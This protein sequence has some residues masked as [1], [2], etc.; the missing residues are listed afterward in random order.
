MG[1]LGFVFEG[2]RYVDTRLPFG[3]RSSPFLF[4]LYAE[5]LHWIL[6]RHVRLSHYLDDFFGATE[7]STRAVLDE[8][9]SIT[10]SLGLSVQDT[11]LEEGREL[12]I[13]GILVNTETGTA[14]ITETRKA[15]VLQILNT[16]LDRNTAS[17][18][19][20]VSI[21]GHLIFI[22]RICPPGRAFLRRIYDAGS[23][24]SNPE[25]RRIPNS[26]VLDLRWWRNILQVWNGVLLLD[27]IR[28]KFEIWSDASGTIGMG[29]HL[30]PM[31]H[32]QAAWSA[33]LSPRLMGN[34]IMTLEAIA[35]LDSLRRWRDIIKNGVVLCFVDNTVLEAALL[36]GSCRHRPTQSVIRAIFHFCL[37]ADVVLAPRWVASEE[38]K[39]ADALSRCA[40]SHPIV[41][42]HVHSLLRNT[43]SP[44]PVPTSPLSPAPP[45]PV[46]FPL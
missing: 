23:N 16:T 26:A 42:T 2:R 33:R 11:K 5:A 44:T 45:S 36:S 18:L 3:C 4:N 39:L 7:T 30:G 43:S 12:E 31:Q 21:A 13:L 40:W 34:D 38:N 1:L 28:P 32:P 10:A 15:N 46:P 41:T 6:Q 20:L 37:D 29:G 25:R 27:P 8:F 14:S 24:L 17:A 22:T 9:K 19:E 35:L